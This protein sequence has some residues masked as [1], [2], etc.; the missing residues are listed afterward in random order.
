MPGTREP[1]KVSSQILWN[2]SF[3]DSVLR[4]KERGGLLSLSQSSK[5]WTTTFVLASLTAL[6][7]PGTLSAAGETE[8]LTSDPQRGLYIWHGQPGAPTEEPLV[9]RYARF[10]WYSLEPERGHYDFSAIDAEL[11]KLPPG[12]SFSFRVMALHSFLNH[13]D[14]V[15]VPAYVAEACPKGFDVPIAALTGRGPAKVYVPDWNCSVFL[16]RVEALLQALGARYDG[17]PRIGAIDIGIYGNW[18]EWHL[19]GLPPRVDPYPRPDLNPRGAEPGSLATR[20]RIIEAHLHA[21]PRTQL[22]M[23]TDDKEA[24]VFA[25]KLRAPIP[26]GLRRDSFGSDHFDQ[27]LLAG[28][29]D[30]ADRQLVEERW[31]TAPFIV[32]CLSGI[33]SSYSSWALMPQQVTRWHISAIGN[34]GF[35][36]GGAGDWSLP[37]PQQR[38]AFLEAAQT[39]GYHLRINSVLIART[40][41]KRNARGLTVTWVNDGVA[42]TYV[43]WKVEYRLCS[44]GGANCGRSVTS[45]LRLSTIL[46]TSNS[47]AVSDQ[48]ILS[49]TPPPDQKELQIRVRDRRMVERTLTL[50]GGLPGT[51]GF[52]AAGQAD[53]SDTDVGAH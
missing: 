35:G 12:G 48:V 7:G 1:V 21:F 9:D 38:A 2:R 23:M 10:M 45:E 13:N 34:G 22:V 46:P 5:T 11:S 25:M 26:I 50:E 41:A 18:G 3:N 49:E 4:F 33:T 20:R 27:D 19:T 51:A 30:A 6:L 24:L 40:S 15:G 17:D 52:L 31:K 47:T 16:E 36:P 37:S 44:P 42:P 28:I 32:E 53:D 39:S 29:R 8:R 43:P 14:G